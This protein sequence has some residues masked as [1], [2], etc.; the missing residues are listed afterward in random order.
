[1]KKSNKIYYWASN[2][3]T[4]SGEGILA[5]SFLNLIKKKYN[6]KIIL[7]N[8]NKF[9]R[10]E[11]FIYNYILPFWGVIKIWKCYLNN[12][13]VCYVNYLPI[14][15][16]LLLIFLPKETILG[17]I[18]GTNTKNNLIYFF[19]KKIGIFIL[20]KRKKKILFSHDQFKKYF[21]R[22]EN[23]FYNFLIYDFK[24]KKNLNKKNYDFIFYYRNNNNKGNNFMINII[25][26]L[27]KKFKIAIIG[28]K[29]NFFDDNKNIV[30]FNN[31]TRKSA[32]QII[33]KSRYSIASKENIF[34]YFTLDCLSKELTVFYKNDLN[35]N[36]FC[37]SNML[38]GIDYNNLSYSLK[39]IKKEIK[40]NKNNNYFKLETKNFLKYKN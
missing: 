17:P 37:Y 10:K 19:F 33:A 9:K 39:K 5:N 1:M 7:K 27:S 13:K 36:N 24:K 8:L 38:V 6:N 20:I 21:Y 14:W 3:N 26:Q 15:N 35:L 16:F 25:N 4:N 23:I 18:T 2:T 11:S 31:L 34:S 30:R 12:K 29:F 32:I 40:S 28:D 22:K